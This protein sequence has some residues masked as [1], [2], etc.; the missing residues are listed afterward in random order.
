MPPLPRPLTDPVRL[1]NLI[2]HVA[3]GGA[4]ITL[5]VDPPHWAQPMECI[6]N[7]TKAIEQ[8]GG[9]EAV[10]GWSLWETFPDLLMEAELHSLWRDQEGTLHDVTPKELPL[11]EPR[12]VFLPDPS[13]RYEGR[14]IENIRVPL[15]D[16]QLIRSLIRIKERK[17]AAFNEGE[18][19]NYHGPVVATPELN[20]VR[21]L[22]DRFMAKAYARYY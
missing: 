19:A 5:E 14:Q 20:R 22:E 8:A 6:G 16:D 1:E 21:E 13:L 7:V 17:F 10:Y 3:P 9:G 12:T 4:V 2:E 18:L 11:L 15:V